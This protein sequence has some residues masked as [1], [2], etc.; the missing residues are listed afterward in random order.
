MSDFQSRFNELLTSFAGNDTEAAQLL[1]VTK[2]AVSN[3]RN[4]SRS[5][6][7]DTIIDIAK[8]FNV[9]IEWLMGFDVPRNTEWDPEYPA[10]VAFR[11]KEP[12]RPTIG[13]TDADLA[14]L[15]RYLKQTDGDEAPHTPQAKILAAGVDKMPEK[16]REKA[17]LVMQ[18]VFQQYADYF[19][20]ETDSDA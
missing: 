12:E 16:E 17:L 9:S 14:T 5:P 7:K 15:A 18:A 1:G 2:Q 10:G 8:K 19:K 13:L 20:E 11:R 6:R 4:G 3:W